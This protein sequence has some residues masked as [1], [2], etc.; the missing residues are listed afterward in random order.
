[1]VAGQ[2]IRLDPLIAEFRRRLAKYPSRQLAMPNVVKSTS[3]HINERIHT[4]LFTS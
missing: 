2:A 1:M 4:I 3:R